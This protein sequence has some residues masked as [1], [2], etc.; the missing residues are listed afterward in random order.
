MTPSV[1][2]PS[3]SADELF[4]GSTGS[5]KAVELFRENGFL[6]IAGF[7]SRQDVGEMKAEMERLVA[8]MDPS[9]LP[10]SVFVAS[11]DEKRHVAD[12]YFLDSVSEIS[13]FYEEKAVC[14]S[15]GKVLV[16][17]GRALNKVG[18]ALHWHN[19]VFKRHT[20][21]Q[22][23]KDLFKALDFKSPLIPQSMY[24][25]KQPRIGGSVG[26]HRDSTFLHVPSNDDGG[27]LVGVWI[28]I[29]DSTKD[30][31]C[32]WFLPGSHRSGGLEKEDYMFVRN[33]PDTLPLVKFIGKREDRPNAEFIPVEVAAGDAVLIDGDVLHKSE[34]NRSEASRHAYTFHVVDIGVGGEWA[35]GNWLQERGDYKFP[36]LYDG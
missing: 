34:E 11:G 27:L 23:I 22:G 14:N 18:H 28:G 10:K 12:Q 29:E 13:F 15:T 20:F 26:Q 19:P 24:I 32:L 36:H 30:N 9:S 6:R 31:G 7:Y 2:V 3:I 33:E 8:E 1:Q 17:K 16:E 35:E 5:S 25:F 21:S 4:S